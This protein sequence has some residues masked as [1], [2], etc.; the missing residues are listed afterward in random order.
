[1]KA[2]FNIFEDEIMIAEGTDAATTLD[3]LRA[4]RDD[5]LVI[6]TCEAGDDHPTVIDEI[7]L[8][9]YVAAEA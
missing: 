9:E 6:T 7:T 3:I 5:E 8:I 4:N 1:M 2:T